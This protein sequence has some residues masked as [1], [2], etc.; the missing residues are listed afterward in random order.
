MKLLFIV[1]PI[2][3]GLDKDPF[4]K[5][6]G[7][8]CFEYGVDYKIFKTTGKH[9]EIHLQK[10]LDAFQPDRVASIGGDGTTLFSAK[11]LI[12]THIP[13]GIIPF[14]SANGLA[15]ELS[16]NTNKKIALIDIIT[17]ELIGN[18]DMILVNNKYH[19]I[20]IGDVGVNAQIVEGYDSD[21]NR[22][23]ITYAK[24]FIEQLQKSKPFSIEI[25]ANNETIQT[26][27]VMVAICN[28]R[29]YGTGVPVNIHG[30]PM[31]GKFE[32]VIISKMEVK[33]ILKAGLSKFDETFF[34][35]ENSHIIKTEDAEI[36]F[37]KKR[38]L[39]LDGEVIGEFKDLQ[40]KI[41]PGAIK[42]ITTSKNVYV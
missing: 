35:S 8:I 13:L 15:M 31:D 29:K 24:Y 21:E 3:G 10:L 6:A 12:D 11:V 9:D 39:Q 34:D 1:N 36:R 14:G 17:S 42:L 40:V 37:N 30:N 19:A 26:E 4:L 23:M 38:L 16:V 41:L 20:H 2:S 32:I 28:G 33:S 22:G 27:G 7:K 18:L 25:E 5:E